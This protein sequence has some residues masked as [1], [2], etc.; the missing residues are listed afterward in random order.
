MIKKK[1]NLRDILRIAEIEGKD[2]DPKCIGSCFGLCDPSDSRCFDKGSP[3]CAFSRACL[4]YTA[5]FF[6][7]DCKLMKPIELLLKVKEVWKK[8][9]AGYLGDNFENEVQK[10]VEYSQQNPKMIIDEKVTEKNF[11]PVESE[12]R[13]RKEKI[14]ELAKMMANDEQPPELKND[15]D[16]MPKSK[17]GTS[18]YYAEEFWLKYGGTMKECAKYVES[19]TN[20][21]GD[22]AARDIKHW[23]TFP[24]RLIKYA[25]KKYK[26]VLI[27]WM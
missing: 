21:R 15:V 7:I 12:S 3:T 27:D 25:E 14:Q 5:E 20:G 22:I 1:L 19:K 9:E 23:S 6:K 26:L 8:Y 10:K 16:L 17:P 11:K 13:E 18:L 24:Y 2:I 4:F